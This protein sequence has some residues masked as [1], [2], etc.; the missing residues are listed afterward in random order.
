MANEEIIAENEKIADALLNFYI[1]SEDE[2]THKKKRLV[3][4]S[5]NPKEFRNKL[6]EALDKARAE[7]M[8]TGEKE[9]QKAYAKGRDIGVLLGIKTG[10]QS[11]LSEKKEQVRKL[12]E[13]LR[14]ELWEIKLFPKEK[15]TAY[16]VA[17]V[18][19]IKEILGDIDDVFPDC[20]EKKMK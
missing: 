18:E 3:V 10:R 4:Y 16:D 12:K 19:Y 9:R 17:A 8:K 2:A 13:Q 11:S 5:A 15:L 7:G 6:L 14:H 1:V 20:V